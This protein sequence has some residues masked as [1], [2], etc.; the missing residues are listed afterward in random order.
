[1]PPRHGQSQFISPVSG[2]NAPS[3]PEGS[4]SLSFCAGKGVDVVLDS[5][6]SEDSEFGSGTRS[7]VLS[8]GFDVATF[9]LAPTQSLV[10]V[11]G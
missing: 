5:V 1:M 6:F 10:I 3:P 9:C 4:G 2:L 8:E 7:V 11:V